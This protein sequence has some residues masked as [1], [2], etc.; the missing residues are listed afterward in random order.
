MI[1]GWTKVGMGLP[2]NRRCL[3]PAFCLL[4][5]ANFDANFP[6]RPGQVTF[7]THCPKNDCGGL[8]IG[9]VVLTMDEYRAWAIEIEQA[10]DAN[11][12]MRP[13]GTPRPDFAP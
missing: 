3:I 10:W 6:L 11:R 13:P 4:C 2:A 1:G 8:V 12:H 5:G 9:R 7:T